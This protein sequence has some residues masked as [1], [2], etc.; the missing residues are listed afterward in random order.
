[1]KIRN[2]FVSNSSSSSFC[3]IGVE[4]DL[5]GR[6]LLAELNEVPPKRPNHG[7]DCE[8]TKCKAFAARESGELPENLQFAYGHLEMDD[9]KKKLVLEY[10]GTEGYV[11]AAGIPAEKVLEFTPL[12]D[13]KKAF[14]ELVKKRLGENINL[15]DIGLRYGEAGSG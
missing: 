15:V 12:C 10:Y 8:C 1:M 9:R 7:E 4:G 6:L 11:A 14:Q 13:A 3:L 2:G 5:A